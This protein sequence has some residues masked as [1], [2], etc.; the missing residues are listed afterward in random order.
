[1]RRWRI[2]GNSIDWLMLHS[3]HDTIFKAINRMTSLP[4]IAL[5]TCEHAKSILR[6]IDN[7]NTD[8][9][10]IM[11]FECEHKHI[12]LNKSNQDY[13]TDSKFW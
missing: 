13:T 6:N 3:S 10:S 4:M 11:I 9:S 7:H 2:Q 1:M 5:F 8:I 12:T